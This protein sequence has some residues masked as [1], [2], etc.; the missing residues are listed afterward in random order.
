MATLTPAWLG[1]QRGREGMAKMFAMSVW[2]VVDGI[3][4]PRVTCCLAVGMSEKVNL[5]F[6][7]TQNV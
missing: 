7:N 4:S 3:P 2:L 1:T 5:P 6:H